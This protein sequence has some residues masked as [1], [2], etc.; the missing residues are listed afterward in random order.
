M[1]NST[2][3]FDRVCND[4][5]WYY[6]QIRLKGNRFAGRMKVN[7]Q[8]E[9]TSTHS[10]VD[11]F[12]EDQNIRLTSEKGRNHPIPL[13]RIRFIRQEDEKEIIQ[14]SSDLTSTAEEIILDLTEQ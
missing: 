13:R 9:V 6:E 1:T 12:L 10:V 11:N 5:R 3:V 2:Y 4:Y 7:T 8:Y 14:I